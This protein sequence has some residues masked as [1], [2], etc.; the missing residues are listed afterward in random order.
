MDIK[1]AKEY[2]AALADGINPLTGEILPEWDS[3]NQ[4]EIV[5]ALHTAVMVMDNNLKHPPKPRPENHGKPWTEDEDQQL[6]E[7][8]RGGQS[9]SEIAKAHI[10]SKGAIAAR[11]VRLGELTD[12]HQLK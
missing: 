11:L 4:A 8:Y 1:Q 3:C 9:G 5:H 2:L 7:E 12:Q 6:L 10:R